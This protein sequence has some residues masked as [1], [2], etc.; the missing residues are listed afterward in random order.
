MREEHPC[1]Q[2]KGCRAAGRHKAP[3]GRG[4]DGQ[5]YVFCLEHVRQYNASYNYF[6]GM[7][8]AE[9]EDFQK[10]A[11]TGHRPTWKM[12]VNPAGNDEATRWRRRQRRA[13]LRLAG[14]RSARV[15][16]APRQGRAHRGRPR[17]G[18]N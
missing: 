3:R 9:V 14:A 7:N 6:D 8:D 15:L 4:R 5:F 2:W 18:A 17:I 1:C 10:E 13:P 16:C 12:G 11:L